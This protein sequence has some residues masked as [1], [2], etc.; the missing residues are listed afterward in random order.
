MFESASP[1]I[2]AKTRSVSG[3]RRVAARSASAPDESGTRCGRPAFIR[4]PGTTHRA[5]GRSIS[6][7]L[8]P[9]TSPERAAVRMVNS[10]AR[11]PVPFSSASLAM[12]AGIWSMPKALW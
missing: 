8:A 11:A 10:S 7:H 1:S 5:A 3:F 12:K 4:S 2:L 9:R 6:D